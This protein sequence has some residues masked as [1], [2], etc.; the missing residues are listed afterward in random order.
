[1]LFIYEKYFIER[2]VIIFPFTDEKGIQEFMKKYNVKWLIWMGQ[3]SKI[4]GKYWKFFLPNEI[5]ENVKLIYKNTG[6]E[7]FKVEYYK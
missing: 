4:D 3:P 5:P 6:G 7:L 1:M 2:P